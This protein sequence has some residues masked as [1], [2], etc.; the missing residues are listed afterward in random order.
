[1]FLYLTQVQSEHRRARGHLIAAG[2]GV[3]E[4]MKNQMNHTKQTQEP[5]GNIY[6]SAQLW[7]SCLLNTHTHMAESQEMVKLTCSI[8]THVLVSSVEFDKF[9]I[10]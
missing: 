6:I 5:C 7:L 8:L 4:N 10:N 9:Q 3:E 2:E 1:M